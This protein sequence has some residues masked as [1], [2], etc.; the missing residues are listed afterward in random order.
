[1][2][3]FQSFLQEF[4]QGLIDIIREGFLEIIFQGFK[5]NEKNDKKNSL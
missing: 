2:N 5:K 3:I 1:M 4:L